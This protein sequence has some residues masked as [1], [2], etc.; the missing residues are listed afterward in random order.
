MRWT[1]AS[2]WIREWV[3]MKRWRERW[4]VP[5]RMTFSFFLFLT[6]YYFIHLML[7]RYY[8]CLRLQLKCSSFCCLAYANELIMYLYIYSCVLVI[9]ARKV[10]YSTKE[11]FQC[12][13]LMLLL[14]LMMLVFFFSFLLST[15]CPLEQGL[16]HSQHFATY[17]WWWI[18]SRM[19]ESILIVY[20]GND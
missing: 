8:I 1:K 6:V 12:M 4:K 3:G 18:V 2:N 9:C 11:P 5:F 7:Y 20:V 13:L 17:R 15:S 19:P 16:C 10:I 14:L